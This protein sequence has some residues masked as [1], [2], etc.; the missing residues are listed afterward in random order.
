MTKQ[1]KTAVNRPTAP[2]VYIPDRHSEWEPSPRWV[3]VVFGNVT[4]ADSRRVMLLRVRGRLPVYYFPAQDVRA[5][6]LTA[7][8][9]ST[10]TLGTAAFSHVTVNGRTA[11]NAAWSYTKL[12]KGAP[13]LKGYVAFVWSKLDVWFEED[14]EVYV[15]ARDPY[16]RI[17]V[18]HS[19]RH[20]RV[21]V[22]GKTVADTRRPCLLFETSLPTRYY[23]P[24]ADVRMEL[25]APTD[26]HTH[27]AYKGVASYYSVKLGNKTFDNFVWY[28]PAPIPECPKIEN[29]LCFFNEKVDLYVDGEL[30]SRPVTSWL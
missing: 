13:N 1:A 28:Y 7:S 24:K 12:A 23:I 27:C 10:A 14:E 19:S 16:H 26:L 20:I 9:H 5:D 2:T 29:L 3:R 11:E 8:K 6:L 15:H 17:D 25:L 21:A 22:R 30:Q 4:V 18:C